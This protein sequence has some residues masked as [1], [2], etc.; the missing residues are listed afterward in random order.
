MKRAESVNPW[1]WRRRGEKGE[2]GE[3]TAWRDRRRTAALRGRYDAVVSV[4]RERAE[5]LRKKRER[6]ERVGLK[7]RSKRVGLKDLGLE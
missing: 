6:A 5:K 4:S 2:A 3:V 1:L 7:R